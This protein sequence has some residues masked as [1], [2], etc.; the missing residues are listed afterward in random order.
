MHEWG[1]STFALHAARMGEERT[2]GGVGRH[3]PLLPRCL[4]CGD[5]PSLRVKLL[6]KEGQVNR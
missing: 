4:G 3:L 6:G 1:V 5:I 2:G